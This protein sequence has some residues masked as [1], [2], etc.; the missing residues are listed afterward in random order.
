MSLPASLCHGDGRD[1]MPQQ[2]QV[3][4]HLPLYVHHDSAVGFSAMSLDPLLPFGWV[5]ISSL[6]NTSL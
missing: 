4:L 2:S 3:L 6:N 1:N 5:K